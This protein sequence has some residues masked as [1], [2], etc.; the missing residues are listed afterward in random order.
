ML[1]GDWKNHRIAI[2]VVRYANIIHMA[3]VG[4]RS[5]TLS[6]TSSASAYHVLSATSQCFPLGTS[7]RA[8]SVIMIGL[9]LC[10]AGVNSVGN[11]CRAYMFIVVFLEATMISCVSMILV[12]R[13]QL[14]FQTPARLPKLL[15]WIAW[16]TVTAVWLAKVRVGTFLYERPASLIFRGIPTCG[17]TWTRSMASDGASTSHSTWASS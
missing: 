8:V 5:M 13:C 11:H 1:H 12:L 6:S 10:L 14:C 16:A 4:G 17:A 7:W 9:I 15:L 2:L 3:M